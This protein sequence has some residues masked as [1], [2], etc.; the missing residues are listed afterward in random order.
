MGASLNH[1]VQAADFGNWMSKQII[2]FPALIGV[3]F[4]AAGFF[5]WPLW[6]VSIIFLG[7]AAYFVYA[8][9]LFSPKGGNVQHQIWNLVLTNLAW[10]GDGR[11]LDIGC[12]NGALSV[13][14]ATKYPSAQVTGIDYWGAK[15]DYSKGIC[16]ANARVEKVAERVV[17]QK[18]S[19]S[20]LP[21]DDGY[22]D[23]VVSNLCF[24]EV[25]NAKDKRA[26]IQEAL[27][28]V[29]KGGKFAF[30][31]LFSLKQLYGTPQ[32]L[33][34]TIKSWGVAEVEFV[35]TRNAPFIPSALKLPLMMGRIGL[36]RG[37]K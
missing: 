17:F 34:E 31:D 9:Y 10:D 33:V 24:H 32:E 7:L 13:K 16:E 28:V 37:K 30:Q 29:K 36:I 15:W 21:F 3:A 8:R 18:A 5:F 2:Y 1:N 26:V 22:F 25:A 11:V 19:A 12:G 27:R 23:A 4:L 35:E 20:R 6:V 14:L